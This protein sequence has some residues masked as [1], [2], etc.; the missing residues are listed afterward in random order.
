MFQAFA[1]PT[2]GPSISEGAVL[3]VFAVGVTNALHTFAVDSAPR[4]TTSAVIITPAATPPPSILKD[5]FYINLSYLFL[6]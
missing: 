2:E 4:L 6:N 1:C 3:V 5:K